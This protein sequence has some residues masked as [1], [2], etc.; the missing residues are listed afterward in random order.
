MPD[1]VLEQLRLANPAARA[2]PL[3]RQLAAGGSAVV[4]LP[5]LSDARLDLDVQAR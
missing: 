5:Y 2:L 4:A 1:K 3:L